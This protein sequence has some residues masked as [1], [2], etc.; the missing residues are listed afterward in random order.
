MISTPSVQKRHD[1][2]R[3]EQIGAAFLKEVC[4]SVPRGPK[5]KG[6]LYAGGNGGVYVSF[7]GRRAWQPLQAEPA[8]DADSRSVVKDDDLG[9]VLTAARFWIL[10]RRDTCFA[11][12]M[13][14]RRTGY[15]SESRY[16]A[17][18]TPFPD[19]REPAEPGGDNPP[20]GAIIIIS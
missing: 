8:G 16:S 17:Y 5:R 6:L 18:R 11:R 10:R 1:G 19:G 14:L 20:N 4:A 13:G 15:A 12:V 7:D 3:P 9:D 2:A